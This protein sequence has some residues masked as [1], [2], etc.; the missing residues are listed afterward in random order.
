LQKF[1]SNIPYCIVIKYKNVTEFI[2]YSSNKVNLKVN[3]AAY[4]VEQRIHLASE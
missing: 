2:V 1:R 3:T 4:P